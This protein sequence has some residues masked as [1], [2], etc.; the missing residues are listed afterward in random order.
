M[1]LET[2]RRY[3]MRDKAD[4]WLHFSLEVLPHGVMLFTRVSAHRWSGTKK[5]L[6]SVRKHF[7]AT[8]GLRVVD[9]TQER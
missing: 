7:P 9:V 5:Q 3:A 4:C 1:A 2:Q 6:D 8:H